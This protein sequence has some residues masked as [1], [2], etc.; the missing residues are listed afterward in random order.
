MNAMAGCRSTSFGPAGRAAPRDPDILALATRLG[1]RGLRYRSFAPPPIGTAAAAPP[2]DPPAPERLMAERSLAA[3]Q[4]PGLAAS[5]LPEMIAP[6][7]VTPVPAM[8]AVPFAA[9]AAPASV[10]PARAL[11]FP[12]LAQA[13][14]RG[15]GAPPSPA[16][17]PAAPFA[18]LRRAG[19]GMGGR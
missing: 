7:M 14:A 15:A 19:A 4:V 16:A 6:A 3:P 1:L 9:A 18:A 12:L 8:P 13:F 11:A 17:D 10:D 5:N 2:A